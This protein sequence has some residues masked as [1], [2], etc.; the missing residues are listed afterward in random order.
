M[1]AYTPVLASLTKTEFKAV[2]SIFR[3]HAMKGFLTI[4]VELAQFNLTREDLPP[5][6][7]VRAERISRELSALIERMD[8]FE[9]LEGN[10]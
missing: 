8:G 1:D 5:A 4:A 3:K 2:I 6:H 9:E 7:R 10:Q